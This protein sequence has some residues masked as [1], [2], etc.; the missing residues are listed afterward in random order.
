MQRGTG[1]RDTYLSPSGQVLNE[2][3]EAKVL[4][5][6]FNANNK[7]NTYKNSKCSLVVDNNTIHNVQYKRGDERE[8]RC[9][10]VANWIE[11]LS[12]RA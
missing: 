7:N 6:A 12:L 9:S 4:D 10:E 2:P 3:H 11:Y 1:V 5:A 8:R